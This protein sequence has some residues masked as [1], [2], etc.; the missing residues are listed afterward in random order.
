MFRCRDVYSGGFIGIHCAGLTHCDKHF[1]SVRPPEML[2]MHHQQEQAQAHGVIHYHCTIHLAAHT[3]CQTLA[4]HVASTLSFCCTVELQATPVGRKD[5]VLEHG[6]CR[7]ATLL[8]SIASFPSHLAV[9]ERDILL[10]L[11]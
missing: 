8:L 9:C 11:P 4:E 1:T 2:G 3:G 5:A 7:P 10:A 6:S